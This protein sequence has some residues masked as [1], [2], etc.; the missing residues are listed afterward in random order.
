MMMTIPNLA[1]VATLPAAAHGSFRKALAATLV[2]ALPVAALPVAALPVAAKMVAVTVVATTVMAVPVTGITTLHAQTPAPQQGRP[3]ALTGGTLHTVAG[4]VIEN[5]T[6]LFEDGRITALGTNVAIPSHAERIDVTGR[7]IYP[8]LVD[9]HSQMGL[10]EIGGFDVTIDVNELGD[11]NPNARAH[12]AFNP[13]SR[14][15]GVA[16]SNGVL[17]TVSSPAGGLISGHSAA[18]MLDGWTW[19]Q[20]TLKPE[21]GLI[22]NWPSAAAPAFGGFGGGPPGGPGRGRNVE[23]QYNES[24]A[25]LSGWFA[26]ARAYRTARAAA[27][28][29]H[30]SDARLEAMIPVV[31]GRVPVVIQANELRQI[32]D[33]VTWAGEEGL[34][35]VLLGG[36]DAGYVAPL[37]AQRQI[38]VLVTSVLASPSRAWEPHD[39]SYAL[40]AELHRAGVRVGITGAASA[41]YAHRLPYEAGAAIAYG[42]PAD[43]ALRAVTLHPAEFLGFADRVGSLEVGKDATLLI[44]TGSPLEYATIIEQAYI[45]GRRIDMEDAHRRFFEKYSE[46]VRQ[47]VRRPIVP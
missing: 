5:G 27:P 44:T 29:R 12:V 43:V 31:E 46:K 32:Q 47:S 45:E 39:A 14:H 11:F 10:F 33:A 20:M 6:I 13:E 7:H 35:M 8:G 1:R 24:I 26:E 40:P 17:V 42:L 4:G 34:R 37:L 30:A 36:R 21:A 38:P 2:A 41:P 3:V 18:M 23:A 15:I 22:I 19:E 9:A 28:G 16:R 25:R